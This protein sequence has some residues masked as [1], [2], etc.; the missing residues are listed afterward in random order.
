VLSKVARWDPDKRWVLAIEIVKTLKQ[1]GWQP[2]LV[3]RGGV[4]AHG[5]E[6]L[7][8]ARE[9]S[10]SVVERCLPQ[11]GPAGLLQML[12]SAH[13]VDV[14]SVRSPLDLDSRRVLFRG[15]AAVLANSGH[16]P[17]GLVGLE[18]MAVGG[19][20][21]TGATGEDYVLA[22]QN[23]LVLETANPQEFVS[24][25]EGLRATPTRERALRQAAQAT[26]RRFVWPQ[27]LQSILLPRLQLLAR[28]SSLSSLYGAAIARRA[29]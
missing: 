26:A 6:V 7:Q 18:T 12:D 13:T 8:A 5:A 22:G 19:V 16:E 11:P 17:F 4:E 3:A 27:I 23:A 15:S 1:Q 14:V 9:A 24:L 29:A 10:L 2:L 21:C 25:F 20:A 28:A